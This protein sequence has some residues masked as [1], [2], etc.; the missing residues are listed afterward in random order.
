MRVL[1]I[2][3]GTAT[4]GWAVI[5][6]S[7]GKIQALAYGHISTEKDRRDED[8]LLEI[9]NDIAQI[10]EKYHPQEAAVESL[11]FF[12]NQKTVIQVAQARGTVLLTLERNNVKVSSYTPLQVK[13][14]ITGYGKAE[15][16]QV[17]LMTKNILGL[18]SVPKP[19]D[20][21]DALAIAVC[22]IHSRKLSSIKS[23]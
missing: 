12:K 21:A 23:T 18:K 16:A 2:D 22:H 9:S 19:D 7:S 14:A 10:I 13:Q 4:T 8:R 20:T 15:K 1:G 11:F 6:E 5:E 3:P 17:Q